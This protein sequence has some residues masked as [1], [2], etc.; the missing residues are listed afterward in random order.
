MKG[1]RCQ[2]IGKTH[3][4]FNQTKIEKFH[5]TENTKMGSKTVIASNWSKT[6]IESDEKTRIPKGF[7][8]E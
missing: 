4:K 6:H 1:D 3:K 2:I 7:P 8:Q 5:M